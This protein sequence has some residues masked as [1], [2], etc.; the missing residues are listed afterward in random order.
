MPQVGSNLD[1]K[2]TIHEDTFEK[3]SMQ[4]EPVTRSEDERHETESKERSTSTTK[5]LKRTSQ[6]IQS[7]TKRQS[8]Q[9]SE[10]LLYKL[11]TVQALGL[12][13]KTLINFMFISLHPNL[14]HSFVALCIKNLF[15]FIET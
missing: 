8:V 10:N 1:D 14:F 4:G 12:W 2:P 9:A 13:L 3:G 11:V 5:P 15:M 6:R 7:L